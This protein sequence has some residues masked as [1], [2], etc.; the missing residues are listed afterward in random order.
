L[1]IKSLGVKFCVDTTFKDLL[2]ST[3]HL[4]SL[5]AVLRGNSLTVSNEQYSSLDDCFEPTN[6]LSLRP[7]ALFLCQFKIEAYFVNHDT[8]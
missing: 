2:Q 7:I 8:A 3:S 4:L 1:P 5:W 6:P